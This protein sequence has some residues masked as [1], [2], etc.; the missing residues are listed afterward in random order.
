MADTASAPKPTLTIGNDKLMSVGWGTV[1][2]V[3]TPTIGAE[4]PAMEQGSMSLQAVG[5]WGSATALLQGSNDG[6]TW[7]T[8]YLVRQQATA[9]KQDLASFTADDAAKVMD[10]AYSQ[11]RV[12][13]S[14]G[15][16]TSL[17]FTLVA[18]RR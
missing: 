5:T 10:D 18:R 12:T 7:K 6:A 8:C 14:G 15:T 3:A 11:Y 2:G 1:T 17:T 16:G 13:T 9:G 4:M